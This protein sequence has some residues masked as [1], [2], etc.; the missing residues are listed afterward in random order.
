MYS[1]FPSINGESLFMKKRIDVAATLA[2]FGT[3]MSWSIVPIF[4]KYFTGYI[5]GWTTN[6]IRYPFSTLLY[7]PWLWVVWRRGVLTRRLWTLALAPT[8]VNFLGQVLWA[9]APYYIDPAFIGFLLRL[10]T[11]WAVLGSFIMFKD[12]RR[13]VRC[14]NFWFGFLLVTGGF[15]M[16][17]LG[18][19]QS[20]SRATVTGIMMMFLCSIFF[21]AYQLFVRRN[22]SYVDSR[23][24]F[25][26]VACMTSA[27]L[28]GCMFGFGNPGQALQM[29]IKVSILVIVSSFIGI[30]VSHLL[31]YFAIKRIGVAI[32]SSVNLTSA[33]IT[34]LLSHLLYHESLSM[35][36]WLAGCTLVGGGILLI[37]AQ[38]ML[39]KPQV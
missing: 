38:T 24:A 1:C 2:L 34:A 22:L 18:G 39:G 20:F 7:I 31:L 35:A 5:D 15:T 16:I 8:V 32:C 9:W 6:G 26:M 30:A 4:L 13:L 28:L 27:G 23:T 3:V 12:E 10:T 37:R 14:K 33:F 21:A 11:L 17:V 19:K 29:P 36:Q 25:G